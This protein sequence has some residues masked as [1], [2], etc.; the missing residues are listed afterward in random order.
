MESF[1]FRDAMPFHDIPLLG[2]L[3]SLGDVLFAAA[4]AA[5]LMLLLRLPGI[6]LRR[7][8]TWR[9]RTGTNNLAAE[10]FELLVAHC[11]ELFPIE[12]VTLHEQVFRR[13]MVVRM[14]LRG[15]QLF[16]G[17]LIGLNADNIIC[18]ISRQAVAADK[19]ESVKALEIVSTADEL[20]P[21]E[22]NPSE[23]SEKSEE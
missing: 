19:L 20:H 8:F 1:L 11:R 3:L 12:T 17:E 22:S 18:V 4:L 14:T 23:E 21:P 15:N 9:L 10:D 2:D 5:I 7:L 6:I 13:G 16:E